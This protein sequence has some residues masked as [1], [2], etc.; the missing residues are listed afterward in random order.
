MT[1]T[2]IL[3]RKIQL[4]RQALPLIQDEI[5]ELQLRLALIVLKGRL[6]CQAHSGFDPVIS[7]KLDAIAYLLEA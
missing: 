6:E 5:I 1:E 7:R 4:K 3:Q 2:Q